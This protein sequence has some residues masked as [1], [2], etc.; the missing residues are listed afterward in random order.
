ML[1]KAI[2]VMLVI[3]A[4]LFAAVA[5]PNVSTVYA[6]CGSASGTVCPN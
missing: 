6:A 1:T 2:R 5:T 3:A 4:L